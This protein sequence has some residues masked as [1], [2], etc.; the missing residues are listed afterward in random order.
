VI[1]V[2]E[3]RQRIERDVLTERQG[4]CERALRRAGSHPECIEHDAERRSVGGVHRESDRPPATSS[5]HGLAEQ[6]DVRVVAAEEPPVERLEQAQWPT[7]AG[8]VD[9]APGAAGCR[10]P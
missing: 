7:P 10:A 8:N 5:R 3:I 2:D 6:C 1:A 9:G 4:E